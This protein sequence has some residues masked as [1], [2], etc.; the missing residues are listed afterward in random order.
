ML[1]APVKS[2]RRISSLFNIGSHK[3]TSPS[4][5]SPSL[6]PNLSPH[7]KSSP[8][9]AAQHRRARSSSRP[10]R[11]ASSPQPHSTESRPKTSGGPIDPLDLNNPLPP[12]PSLLDVN[13]DLIDGASSRPG[14][15]HGSSRRSSSAGLTPALGPPSRPGTPGESQSRG[16]RGSLMPGGKSRNSSMDFR[17]HGYEAWVAGLDQKIPYDLGPLRRGE[18]VCISYLVD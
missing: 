16:K 7:Q 6:S 1:S 9:L 18:A 17:S 2:A 12:P 5:T 10:P 8:D 13:Q 15:S 14:S 3:D 4:S 11:H